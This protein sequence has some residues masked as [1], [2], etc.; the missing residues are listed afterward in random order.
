MPEKD[1]KVRVN[2]AI[3]YWKVRKI[4]ENRTEISTEGKSSAGGDIPEWLANM[5]VEDNPY[6]SITNLVKILEAPPEE[7]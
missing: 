3:G 6:N 4:D 1:D 7:K 5:F 2:K